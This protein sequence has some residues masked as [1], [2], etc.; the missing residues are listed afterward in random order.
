MISD[1]IGEGWLQQKSSLGNRDKT[2]TGL[3]LV[4]SPPPPATSGNSRQKPGWLSRVCFLTS[5]P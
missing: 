4:P 1:M 3:L 5:F 2:K